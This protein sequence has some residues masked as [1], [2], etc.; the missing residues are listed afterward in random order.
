MKTFQC[1]QE[2]RSMSRCWHEIPP[3]SEQISF[4]LMTPT[5]KVEIYLCFI[6][7]P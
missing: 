2:G 4:F 6:I 7:K 1:S 5:Y 3:S